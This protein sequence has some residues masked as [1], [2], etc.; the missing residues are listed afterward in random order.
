MTGVALELRRG[1]A[2]REPG[3]AT[4]VID[5]SLQGEDQQFRDE[6]SG[7]KLRASGAG[8]TRPSAA[9]TP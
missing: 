8:S 5:D 7:D 4:Q 6:G 2:G 1:D 3:P 9:L